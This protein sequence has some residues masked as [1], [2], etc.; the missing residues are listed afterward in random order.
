MKLK[1]N[2]MRHLIM[3]SLLMWVCTA[4]NGQ[5]LMEISYT[6]GSA[7]EVFAMSDI[8][9]MW[10]EEASLAMNVGSPAVKHVL[11]LKGIRKIQFT[12]STSVKAVETEDGTAVASVY[13]LQGRQVL[14]GV[15][16]AEVGGKL[17]ALPRG[18][19]LVK[20]KSK[21]IKIAN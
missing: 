11:P 8:G 3:L 5:R 12:S 7:S 17:R 9:R 14:T 18:V 20:S 4:A 15:S 19:Y 16:A 2:G 10:F 13:D 1:K 6:G 21:T